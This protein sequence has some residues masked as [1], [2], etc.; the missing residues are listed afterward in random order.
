MRFL[1]DFC[2]IVLEDICNC[3]LDSG[4][5]GFVEHGNRNLSMCH[6]NEKKCLS[7]PVPFHALR[8]CLELEL[9]APL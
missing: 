2:V 5:E 1:V 7:Y 6:E 8:R 9:H 3:Q 4:V